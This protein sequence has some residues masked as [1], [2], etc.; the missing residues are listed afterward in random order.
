MK[1]T[2]LTFLFVAAVSSASFAQVSFGPKL[3]LGISNLKDTKT[4]NGSATSYSAIIT[5]IVGV[6]LNAQLTDN[7]AIRPELLFLQRGAK[8][9]LGGGTTLHYR[10]SYIE[11]PIN[12]VGGFQ[13][14]PGKLEAFVGPSFG[15]GLGGHYKVEGNGFSNSGSIKAKKMPENF[16]GNNIYMNPIN[17][18]LNFGI[19]YKFDNGLLFQLG[20]NLGFSN[21][22]PH[23]ADSN[24]E[25]KRNED[26][27]KA[28][29]VNFGIAYLFG[30]K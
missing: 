13:A 17:V 9:D 8:G 3:G 27:T 15:F 22:A 7:F 6:V 25:S 30:G 20:Y 23:Y 18:S 28:S 2:L 24:L 14:G 26:V 4:S 5:P 19:D 21:I 16:S 10:A 11:V 12:L 29:S 1:K